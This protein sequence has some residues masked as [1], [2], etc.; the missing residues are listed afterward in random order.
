[1]DILA[2]ILTCSVYPDDHLIRAMVELA[3][4]EN[5]HFVGDLV[6][7]V[8]FDRT[9]S[10]T[11][12]QRVVSE[13]ERRGG[14][15]VVGLLGVPVSWGTRYKK[16]AVDLFDAC[17][18]LMVGSSVLQSHYEACSS[19]HSTTQQSSSSPRRA[20]VA[21]PEAIRQ[22][23]LRRYGADLGI[24]G[25]AESAL[26]YFSRQRVLFADGVG[27]TTAADPTCQCSEAPRPAPR[28]TSSSS[29][30]SSSTTGSNTTR[31][32]RPARPASPDLTDR[33]P[34]LSKGPGGAPILE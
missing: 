9:N 24:D 19:A 32:A 18:N 14:K 27:A 33:L 25:Y 13:L 26:R 30:S 31:A 1:M 17:T 7:L 23:A 21:P 29:S 12:A 20:R 11:E 10:V 34:A 22:C 16:S 5:P 2:L 6:T 15:P 4:Q 28:R 3:S 8:T